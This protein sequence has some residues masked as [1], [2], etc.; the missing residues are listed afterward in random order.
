MATNLK[1][2]GNHIQYILDKI[3]GFQLVSTFN[4]T[5]KM[6][7]HD[8]YN[9]YALSDGAISTKATYLKRIDICY[10][11]TYY[12]TVKHNLFTFAIHDRI[13][14]NHIMKVLTDEQQTRI[15]SYLGL[16]VNCFVCDKLYC[17]SHSYCILGDDDMPY[18]SKECFLNC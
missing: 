17:K 2:Q 18:C 15:L 16:N 11:T 9:T 8:E 1:V 5:K 3:L 14:E 12:L 7:Y 10:F 6:D 13:S 4:G